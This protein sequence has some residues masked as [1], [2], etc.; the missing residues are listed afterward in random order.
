MNAQ[1]VH[2]YFQ[3]LL[4]DHICEDVIHKGLES[5]RSIAKSK[6]HDGWFKESKR[7]DEC[8]LPLVLFSNMNVVES[9]LDVELGKDHRIVHVINQFRNKGQG[10]CIADGVRVQVAIVLA[11]AERAIFLCNK[12]ERDGLWGLGW[13][14]SSGFE[15]FINESFTCFRSFGLRG[16]TLAIFKMND[17]LRT[18]VWSY[19]Q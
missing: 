13:N 4:S 10:I 3:P 2:V 7:G 9:P 8:P 11:R 14:D 5:R 18:M 17:G 6:E 19:D 12:E 16:Y 15:V 1:V